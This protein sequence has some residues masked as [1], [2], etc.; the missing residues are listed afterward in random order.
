MTMS[1][2]PQ[3]EVENSRA[4][5]T[6]STRPHFGERAR[7]DARRNWPVYVVA[8]LTLANGLL[9]IA[10]I[11]LVRWP[12]EPRLFSV[13]L[14]FG[15]YHLSRSLTLAFGLVLVYLS[16]HLFR[17]RKAAL[18]LA[19]GGCAAAA[20]VHVVRG[21]QGYQALAPAVTLVVLL[22]TRRRFTVRTEPRSVAHGL[23]AMLL[24]LSLA[25]AYGAL[26]FWLMDRRDFGLNFRWG[27]ALLR[28]LREFALV[29]NPDLVAHTRHALWFLDSL[30]LMGILSGSLALYSLFRP[31]AYRLH[32][33]PM[34]RSAVEALLK[35][36]GGTSLDYFK[37]ST[38]KS[39]FFSADRRCC[40]AYHAALG[41]AIGLGDPVGP[42]EG[43]QAVVRDFV[44]YC[45]DN[46]WSAAFHQVQPELLSLYRACGLQ[47]L[48]IGE[49][50]VV[51]L[52]HFATVTM[53]GKHFR[54]TRN[55]FEKEGCRFQ[56]TLPPHAAALLDQAEEVSRDWLQLPGHRERGF[57]LGAFE[58]G[59]LNQ[60]P[61]DALFAAD[62]RM[63]AFANEIP[64]YRSGEAT[65][66]LMRHRRDAP[67]SSMDYLFMQIML[68][69]RQQGYLTFNLG[70]APYAGVGDDPTAPLEER[71]VHLLAEHA[72]RFFS[73]KGMRDYKAKF[74][75]RWEERYLVHQ[76]GAA[77][78]VKTALA[79]E[80]M[81]ERIRT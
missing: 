75:P 54:H 69:L 17:R 11:T 45:S 47:A 79:L 15:L 4:E 55:W 24:L 9:G 40:V 3:I 22:L 10:T 16:A 33:L 74:D 31:L 19:V 7:D 38:D 48:K 2:S 51:E 35:Q 62:G 61:L 36:Y 81:S 23:L 65:I 41:V 25:V 80:Q 43:L 32:T 56:H 14:P 70:M 53:G 78:L 52:E 6:A 13:P 44:Q 26:G 76:G 63:I 5:G 72:T 20:L 27:D 57:T 34:E 77:G 39:Y 1:A 50:A 46:G 8:G 64:S 28:T 59:Y 30:H 37:L 58:H 12:A 73:Y 66:D 67:D 29:G 21:H 68:M 42:R 49:E 60:C 18:W 71:G